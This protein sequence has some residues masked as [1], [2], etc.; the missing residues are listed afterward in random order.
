[1]FGHALGA[2]V[3]KYA[4]SRDIK[5]RSMSR[6]VTSCVL[7]GAFAA[8][9]ACGGGSNQQ[10]AG[11]QSGSTADLTVTTQ[12]PETGPV[13][14][15]LSVPGAGGAVL[16][17][18]PDGQAYYSPDGFNL[19]GGGSTVSA[20]GG[21]LKIVDIVAVGAGVDALFAD[22]SVYF[23]SDGTNLGGGG[24]TVRA[25]DGTPQVGS[26]V[27]V[28]SGVDAVFTNGS[29]AYYSPDG[30]HLGGGGNSIRI[31][32]GKT[33]ILQI[34]PVGPGDAVV[35]LLNGGAAY[36]SPD[37]RN[38]GG[39]GTTVSAAPTTPSPI[40]ALVRVGGGLL[41]QFTNGL[42]YLSPDGKN[43]AGGGATIRVAAW[44]TSI[45][46]GPFRLRDSAHGADFA[47]R[48]WLSGGFTG[49]TMSDSC[50]YTCSFF[51]LWSSTDPQGVSWNS[52][53]DF[54]TASVPNPRDATPVV[55]DGVQDAPI[56]Q[57]FYDPYSALVVW[58]G[59]LSAIGA[60]VW[61]SADGVTWAR[62]NLADGVTA[63]PGPLPGHATE[64]SRALVLSASLFYVQPDS[65]EVYRTN[66]P[67][68]VGWTDLG[69][70]SGFQTRCGAA[71]FVSL[72]KIWIEGGGMCDYSA[73]FNDEWSSAD[74]ITWTKSAK[75]AE[76]SGR[77]WPCAAS[78]DD[79]I[80]WLTGGY[81]PTDYTNTP[82]L[83]VRYAA[84]HADVWYSKNGADWRQLKADRGSGLTDDGGLE[85]RHAPT[86][87]V[88]A[89]AKNLVIIAGTGGEDPSNAAITTVVLNSIRSLPLP[90][91]ASLP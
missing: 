87:Y 72:G 30:Q 56:P 36:Y 8:L 46:N 31:Y 53:P 65:G 83:A 52:A 91:T 49:P 20:Y 9:A 25:F 51:E 78:S 12:G 13:K 5:E 35:T 37:N 54:E 18:F 71:V 60:T 29:G 70:I 45:P 33:D 86:C 55:N 47:G 74:G 26:L 28:G 62:Q 32:S 81:A 39:G 69:Q 63:A 3:R 68:A 82:G 61:N 88:T 11:T 73:V 50:F 48:L 57:D 80:V 43:L 41:T 23:S 15:I 17:L 7:T 85:P 59:H 77:M 22:G 79:G 66:D 42:V 1:L 6:T 34:E 24:S 16:A 58:N 27:A 64:N 44:D 40:K 4:V 75:L 90:A 67:N 21:N 38:L 14:K 76:W 10:P 84:N 19:A 89:G 2:R